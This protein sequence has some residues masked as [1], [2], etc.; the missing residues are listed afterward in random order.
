MQTDRLNDAFEAARSAVEL[1]ADL[2]GALPEEQSIAYLRASAAD[3]PFTLAMVLAL[4]LAQRAHDPIVAAR[5][6]AD[7]FEFAEMKKGRWFVALLAAREWALAGPGDDT[8]A[9]LLTELAKLRRRLARHYGHQ[10]GNAIDGLRALS[11]AARAAQ[12]EE[13]RQLQDAYQAL[14]KRLRRE[15]PELASLATVA[16]QPLAV[17]QRI[18]PPDTVLIDICAV[19]EEGVVLFVVTPDQLLM[20][21]I[22]IPEAT[23]LRL[24]QAMLPAGPLPNST[25]LGHALH[26]F[27]RIIWPKLAPLLDHAYPGWLDPV[28]DDAVPHLVLVPAGPLHRW[29]LH[30]LSLPDGSGQLLD[31]FAVSYAVTA[32]TPYYC[33][34]HPIAPEAHLL[35]LAPCEEDLPFSALEADAVQAL[36]PGLASLHGI[37]ASL[38]ALTVWG[39]QARWQVWAT[40]AWIDGSQDPWGQ[41]QLHDGPLH[42]LE[43]IL[44]VRLRAEHLSLTACQAHGTAVLAGDNL[45]GLTR[46]LLYAGCRSLLTTL[47]A[48]DDAEAAVLDHAFWE[49]FLSTRQSADRCLRA[50][51]RARRDGGLTWLAARAERVQAQ[52]SATPGISAEA[53]EQLEMRTA[54][55]RYLAELPPNEIPYDHTAAP[56]DHAVRWGA[57]V[58]HG[59]AFDRIQPII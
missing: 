11:P 6:R 25:S 28:A 39:P 18:L 59:A 37:S 13:I 48:I 5:Y 30:L 4:A 52:L 17:V 47:W 58:V 24:T 57:F 38:D 3:Q 10:D 16:P 29:P 14:L 54:V 19:E 12:H 32:D 23:L 46:A 49:V 26:E 27:G 31:R 53:L 35:A 36:A 41:I 55:W 44:R 33:L 45:V 22:E 34:R 8:S 21:G 9:A 2:V 1:A 43:L 50:V 56:L 20:A 15:H 40:H 42:P 7:A 51:L